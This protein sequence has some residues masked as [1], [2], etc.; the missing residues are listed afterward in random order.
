M[1]VKAREYYK[2]NIDEKQ[3]RHFVTCVCEIWHAKSRAS[4][5]LTQQ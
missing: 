3:K 1:L 2:E 5:P 4:S